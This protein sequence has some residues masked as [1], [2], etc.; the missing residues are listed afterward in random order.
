MTLDRDLIVRTALRLLDDVGLEKLSLRR[1][2]KELDVHATALYW[3]F[4]SKQ[5]LLDAMG[6]AMVQQVVAEGPLPRTWQE[7]LA[8]LARAQRQ[9]VRSHRDGALLMMTARPTAEHQVE[10]LD[11][12]V[13]RLLEAGFT[14]ESAA[15]AFIAVSNFAIGAAFAEQQGRDLGEEALDDLILRS[16]EHPGVSGIVA[17]AQDLDATFERGLAWLL[18]GM[19]A[20]LG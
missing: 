10:Y 3:H 13:G 11:Q 9:A 7:W 5:E 4:A 12:L 16:G 17:A 18:A 15:A 1:L 19:R 20:E 6:R 2:A 8:H 14:A